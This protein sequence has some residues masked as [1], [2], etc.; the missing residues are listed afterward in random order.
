MCQLVERLDVTGRRIVVLAAP[1]DRRDEDIADIGRIAAGHFDRYILR[2]DDHLRGRQP[3]EVPQLLR[4]ALL[5]A[6]VAAEQILVI[7]DEQMATD[8]ALREAQP[9]DLLL[10]FG[11]AITRS[12][13]QVIQFRPEAP[14]RLVE[15]PRTSRPEP[16]A[17]ALSPLM[18]DGRR[19]FVRDSRGVWLPREE[20]AD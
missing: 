3:D 16:T 18:D 15:R 17:P 11:D 1:G 14:A 13:K 10:I 20:T 6:G 7:P 2:R 12:W 4:D 19:E 9:G 5:A 8:T